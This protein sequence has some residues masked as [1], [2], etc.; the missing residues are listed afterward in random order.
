LKLAVSKG[1]H[2]VGATHLP[3][4]LP[5]DGSRAS[6]QNVVF[7]KKNIGRWIKSKSKI[8]R[9]AL[10]VYG[11]RFK[12]SFSQVSIPQLIVEAYEDLV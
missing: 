3:P 11:E 6:F 12:G 5:E 10:E 9:N 8:P 4:F 2:R 1:H 7:F